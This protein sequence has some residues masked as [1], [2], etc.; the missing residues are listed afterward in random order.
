MKCLCNHDKYGEDW[1][2]NSKQNCK[3]RQNNQ[4]LFVFNLNKQNI[5]EENKEQKKN[6]IKQ[7]WYHF[8]VRFVFILE[9]FC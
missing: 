8:F 7:R 4:D 9:K 1:S 6:G 3:T 2:N 5:I